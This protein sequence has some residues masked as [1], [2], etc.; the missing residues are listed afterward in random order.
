MGVPLEQSVD[1]KVTPALGRQNKP[2]VSS[3]ANF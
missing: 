1:Q 3:V 2:V